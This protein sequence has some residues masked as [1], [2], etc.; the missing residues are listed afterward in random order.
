MIQFPSDSIS[1]Q[2]LHHTR[3]CLFPQPFS[4][5]FAAEAAPRTP[6]GASGVSSQAGGA[7]GRPPVGR[8]SKKLLLFS[9]KSR[10]CNKNMQSTSFYAV[11]SPQGSLI[12]TRNCYKRAH[13]RTFATKRE[14]DLLHF[15]EI[16]PFRNKKRQKPPSWAGVY[17]FLPSAAAIFVIFPRK[18][19]NLKQFSPP[20]K[21]SPPP[22]Q[23]SP[24][25][26]AD[27]RPFTAA[28]QA[29]PIKKAARKFRAASNPPLQAVQ[30]RIFSL[31]SGCPAA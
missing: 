1:V 11:A 31:R 12:L 25:P 14:A 7:A 23:P 27:S 15:D 20:P 24:P 21:P 26:P 3:N 6:G 16:V 8:W 28:A 9:Q 13:L 4:V 22:P 30:S 10:F 29:E 2:C 5:R 19:P 18:M 17:A